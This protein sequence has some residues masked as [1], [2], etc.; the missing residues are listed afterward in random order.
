MIRVGFVCLNEVTAIQ[1]LLPVFLD[2]HHLSFGIRIFKLLKRYA[3][4]L[5]CF[6]QN[7]LLPMSFKVVKVSLNFDCSAFFTKEAQ[8][9]KLV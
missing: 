9:D 3:F 8:V 5:N 1:I 4:D 2:L 6:L 7:H